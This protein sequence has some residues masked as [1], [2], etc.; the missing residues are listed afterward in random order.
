MRTTRTRR[1]KYVA[2][3][4]LLT[5]LAACSFPIVN[6]ANSWHRAFADDHD[7]DF[8]LDGV[9][10]GFRYHFVD[11]DPDGAFYRVPN[12]VRDIHAPK[13][14]AW[15]AAETAAGRYAP[16]RQAFARGFAALGV[17]D[18]DH[19]DMAKV[20]VVHDLSRSI[21]TSTNL[22]ISIEHCSLPTVR[23]AF[24]LLRPKLFQAKVDL[25]SAY[26]SVPVHPDH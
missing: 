20:R 21:G 14:A 9:T 13:V 16:I 15:I 26:R 25:T 19:S 6:R 8:V 22:G 5:G 18:N 17:V 7:A 23:D 11:P 1:A 3:V 10:D 4:L 2:A 24:D 12:Y